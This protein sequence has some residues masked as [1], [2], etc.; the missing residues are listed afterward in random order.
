MSVLF[1]RLLEKDS[2]ILKQLKSINGKLDVLINL[3]RLSAPKQKPTKEEEKIFSLC[4][5]KNTIADMMKK[6]GKKRG[7]IE[8]IISSLRNKTLINSTYIID[9]ETGKKKTVYSKV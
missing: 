6:T 8:S 9:K 7:N 4:N 5:M 1:L 2:E 3:T